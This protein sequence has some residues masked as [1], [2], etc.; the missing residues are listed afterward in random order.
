M[1][2]RDTYD[3]LRSHM[4]E[5]W[6]LWS[7]SFLAEWD[8]ETYMP[9]GGAEARANMLG[10]LA[11]LTH[12]M[13][14]DPRVN[15]WLTECESSDLAVGDTI[16]AA[17]IREL[18]RRYNRRTTL[19]P[20]FVQ[21]EA[22]LM[23]ESHQVWVQARKKSD[24]A[25]FAPYLEKV[26]AMQREKADLFGFKTEAY[27][28]LMDDYEPGATAAEIEA[29]FAGLLPELVALN[30]RLK[31][32]PRRPD[33]GIIKRPYDVQKQRIFSEMVVAALG[34][35]FNEGRIDEV[36]HPFCT[37]FGPGDHRIC[38]RYYPDDLA[39]GLT[40][41]VHEA[42]HA[43]Y[44]MGLNREDYGMPT[45]DATSLGIHESQSRMWENQVGRSR[46]FWEYFFPQAQRIFR[47]SLKD[48]TLEQF[49][50]AMNYSAPSFIR[51]EADEATYN[52]HIMLRFDIER[53]ILRGDLKVADIPGEWNKRFKEYFGLEV[54]KDSNG[55][56]QDVHW[57]MGS[58]GYFPTYCLG[59]LYAA[60]FY[61][62]ANE[63]M[64]GLESDFARGDFSRL[65][66]WL[67]K[68]IHVHGSRYRAADLCR[69][70]T[71]EPLSHRPLI[72]YMT[73][74]YEDIYGI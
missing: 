72:A 74:K 59:N 38:T 29:V 7:T 63:E 65:L 31:E 48:V 60:Q 50:H 19:P 5:H 41:V 12:E 17:N 73:E 36:A 53:A 42:G 10:L 3:K 67:R 26:I 2:A 43:M 64:P 56:L 40:G 25:M 9:A 20:E 30:G 58:L 13:F 62:K 45:G 68:N 71:G 35:D 27:D 54:D 70:V 66:G 46:G 8:Q 33:I 24:F 14:T 1:A 44:D 57:S 34:Y 61:A 37:S 51:V 15:E 22:R 49:H 4:K 55:C 69:R 32:A 18:R 23:S 47:E 6:T 16:E 11:R 28:A 21:E 52:L 39:E